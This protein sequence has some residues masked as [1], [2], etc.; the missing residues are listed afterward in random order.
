MQRKD[1]FSIFIIILSSFAFTF[2]LNNTLYYKNIYVYIE[3]GIYVFAGILS[4]LEYK[5][6]NEKYFLYIVL[7]LLFSL[8]GDLLSTFSDIK[9]L[10]DVFYLIGYAAIFLAL[11]G[12][13]KRFK[14]FCYK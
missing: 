8:L 2:V 3:I 5:K 1:K 6:S 11:N 10:Y 14:L 4:Y 13:Y 7:F 9:E 12:I